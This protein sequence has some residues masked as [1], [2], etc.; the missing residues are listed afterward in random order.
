M[1]VTLVVPAY[2]EE[3]AVGLVI[4]EYYP[5]VDELIVVDDGSSDKTYDIASRYADEKVIIIGHEKNRGK[6]EALMTGVARAT[7]DVIVF[8]DADCTYPARNIP[9]FIRELEQ[10]ADLVLGTRVIDASNIPFLNR[11][12]NVVFST[13]ATY[14]SGKTITDGQTGF[15][16]FKRSMFESLHVRAKSLEFETKMTVRAAKLGYVIVEV[17][18][19]YRKRVGTS[20]LHPIR[21]GY[22][23]LQSLLSIAWHETSPLAKMISVPGLFIILVGIFLS[24]FVLY[25]YYLHYYLAHQYY[26]L[27]AI[28][29]ILMGIQLTSLGLII[30]YLTKKL[31]RIE[32]QLRR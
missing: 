1:K 25:D 10:G 3:E 22:R 7:G 26:P 8:T 12:G 6:V 24:L 18:I 4:E 2:N 19:E 14:I 27:I 32:E 17:P 5:F 11:I 23:M 28:F 16:A 20:K 15:R 30:D 21:D 31:D 9:D 13:L 29:S